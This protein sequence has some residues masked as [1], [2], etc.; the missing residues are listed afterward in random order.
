M[1]HTMK[2]LLAMVLALALGIVHPVVLS[3]A[4]GEEAGVSADVLSVGDTIIFGH[5]EQDNKTNNGK[6]EIEWKVLDVD[7][8]EGRALLL[9]RYN[10]DVRQFDAK[11][12]DDIGFGMYYG[13]ADSDIRE[14]LNGEFLETAFTAEEQ[15]QIRMTSVITTSADCSF[16]GP[17]TED[18]VFLLNRNEAD[19]YFHAD[20]LAVSMA[21]R[22][23]HTPYAQKHMRGI[24]GDYKSNLTE[25]GVWAGWW[26]LRTGYSEEER[27][28]EIIDQDGSWSRTDTTSAYI[29]VRPALWLDLREAKV[30]TTYR[31]VRR[32]VPVEGE[33]SAELYEE[34]KR[35][36]KGDAVKELQEALKRGGFL[37]GKADGDFGKMTEAAVRKAQAVLGLE[38]TGIADAEFQRRLYQWLEEQ[39]EA[40]A[41][42]PFYA[43]EGEIVRFGSYEQDGDTSNGAEPIE[44]I[45]LNVEGQKALLLSKYVLKVMKLPIYAYGK[46][47]GD[48]L[49]HRWHESGVRKWLNG[50]FLSKGFTDEEKARMI[51]TDQG[52]Y[53]YRRTCIDK[54]FILDKSLEHVKQSDK[55]ATLTPYAATE[56][57]DAEAN[58]PVTWWLRDYG[59][60]NKWDYVNKNGSSV[61]GYSDENWSDTAGVRPAMYVSV[62][63]PPEEMDNEPRRS[64]EEAFTWVVTVNGLRQSRDDGEADAE[65]TAEPAPAEEPADAEPTAEPAP[66]EEPA[67]AEPET[68]VETHT[69]REQTVTMEVPEQPE[70]TIMAGDVVL[71]GHYE[72]D[73]R[74]DN[75]PE[76]I[77]W[78]VLTVADGMAL[79]LSEQILDVRAFDAD[80]LDEYGNPVYPGWADSDIRKWL[81]GEFLNSAFAEEERQY[82]ARKELT[83]ADSDFTWQSGAG[84]WS[85]AGQWAYESEQAI[86]GGGKSEDDIF[87]LSTEN[88]M[89]YAPMDAGKPARVSR[90]ASG[91][92]A[93]SKWWTRSPATREDSAVFV[94][95]N[96][97][98]TWDCGM[99]VNY[100]GMGIRPAMWMK[101]E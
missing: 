94:P 13:W 79:L 88:I 38:E 99:Q 46:G 4:L 45:V 63:T 32:I 49:Y 10:L 12:L 68:R 93:T 85:G 26:W 65:P 61:N 91:K 50:D 33:E 73:G 27:W 15:G 95:E 64:P 6:E 89:R 28:V 58:H 54:I 22:T 21:R 17:D 23:S 41:P 25:E 20:H 44:W 30:T 62:D 7:M 92:G 3:A 47:T 48:P 56:L 55:V 100:S 75:G 31:V 80:S 39:A 71:F 98:L 16:G 19:L 70:V 2:I 37:D 101:V 69:V 81:N 82:I 78:Q 87:L 96:G 29:G 52:L 77:E 43:R 24:G 66:A 8:T 90:Y 42:E 14:W 67:D 35:G 60:W 34:L 76:E 59:S 1:K 36:D 51:E 11:H 40:N 18:K 5:Y 84:V 86:S 74:E 57:K 72:Q 83:T 97:E 53:G 9:S